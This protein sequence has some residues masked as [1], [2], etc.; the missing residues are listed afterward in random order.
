MLRAIGA[1]TGDR[2]N[3]SVLAFEDR[4]VG[5]DA[6]ARNDAARVQDRP[7][8]VAVERSVLGRQHVDTRRRDH[9]PS[10]VDVL[11]HVRGPREDAEV[12]LA[13]IRAEERPRF[14]STV[15]GSIDS[16]MTP[17]HHVRTVPAQPGNEPGGLRIMQD[18]DVARPNECAQCDAIGIEIALVH[19]QL[20]FGER[21]TVAA[22]LVETMVQPFG[23][24][25]EAV[26]RA[27]HEPSCVD[28]GA[29]S[30]GKQAREEFGDTAAP[31]RGVDVPHR[32]PAEEQAN[33]S[34]RV[35]GPPA[36]VL[37]ERAAKRPD[38]T[39]RDSHIF[40]QG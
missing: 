7:T 15:A 11:P 26:G 39:R 14:A 28:S 27:D 37:A 36:F 24:V 12:G 35:F 6:R 25:E 16:D 18:G 20:P 17:P 9:H 21:A 5:A 32:A 23:D 4:V 34:E 3:G 1:L 30:V 31:R 19:R 8:G 29:A 2:A 40:H 22:I 10:R 33:T 13:N 38:G